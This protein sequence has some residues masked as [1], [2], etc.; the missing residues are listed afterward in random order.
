MSL[1][2]GTG[3]RACTT[4]CCRL[5][6]KKELQDRRLRPMQG[7]AGA[8]PAPPHNQHQQQPQQQQ[9]RRRRS[10]IWRASKSAQGGPRQPPPPHTAPWAQPDGGPAQ[11]S[12]SRP[13]PP[14]RGAQLQEHPHSNQA[15]TPQPQPLS[16]PP[17]VPTGHPGVDRVVRIRQ[18]RLGFREKERERQREAQRV[19]GSSRE[20]HRARHTFL[21]SGSAGSGPAVGLGSRGGGEGP[22][23]AAAAAASATEDL[24]QV[25]L[26]EPEGGQQDHRGV[27]GGGG[28]FWDLGGDGGGSGYRGTDGG[29]GGSTSS[30][31]LRE[32][33]MSEAAQMNPV[34]RWD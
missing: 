5:I 28:Y 7:Q 8:G 22:A 3:L 21:P 1:L 19:P 27:W 6:R 32:A 11:G 29:S 13:Q 2:G 23:A 15:Q 20:G 33:L 18:L 34:Y 30:S 25:S 10:E 12:R 9:R 24:I 14:T 17:I 26:A 4:T 31:L 16:P